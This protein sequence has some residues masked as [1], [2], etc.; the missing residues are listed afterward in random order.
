MANFTW[1]VGRCEDGLGM[2]GHYIRMFL[3]VCCVFEMIERCALC[4]TDALLLGG[5][6][7]NVTMFTH[8]H[9]AR[10]HDRIVYAL[11]GRSVLV[12]GCV[13]RSWNTAVALLLWI[14]V[15]TFN[16]DQ[17][18][19]ENIGDRFVLLGGRLQECGLP[20]FGQF[21]T[22]LIGYGALL[23]QIG[24]VANEHDGSAAACKWEKY[25]ITRCVERIGKY[26]D[27]LCFAHDVH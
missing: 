10:P 1:G 11:V 21:A 4:A 9:T 12:W 13:F 8:T 27:L 24:L 2:C 6:I 16:L 17:Q 3:C 22:L 20:G 26:V 7:V 5:Y 18:R 19:W 15:L 25:R 14:A 23:M